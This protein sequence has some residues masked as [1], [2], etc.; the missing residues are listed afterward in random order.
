MTTIACKQTGKQPWPHR[1]AARLNGR[2]NRQTPRGQKSLRSGDLQGANLVAAAKPL[3]T[4]GSAKWSDRFSMGPCAQKV[5][6]FVNTFLNG[7]VSDH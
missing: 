2:G 4:P 3:L 1:N 5:T 6:P 7:C